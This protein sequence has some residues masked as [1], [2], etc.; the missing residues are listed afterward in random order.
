MEMMEPQAPQS[1]S[2]DS[3]TSR[4][5]APMPRKLAIASSMPFCV[6]ALTLLS[7]SWK[8]WMTPIFS[9]LAPRPSSALKSGTARLAL[10]G[11][12]GSWPARACSMMAQ[13]ST[14]QA[15]GPMWS[16]L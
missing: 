12:D 6:A 1:C 14:V 2:G 5:S 4:I 3:V 7:T 10:P 16:R 15:I 8:W 11:S 13:S 9:P